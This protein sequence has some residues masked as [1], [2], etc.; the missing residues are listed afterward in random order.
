MPA[1][2]T[3]LPCIHYLR[4]TVNYNDVGI[5]GGVLVGTL[6]AG[7]QITD[8][9][10]NVETA[11]NG[12]SPVLTVGTNP[13][14][15]DNIAGAADINE[16]SATGQRVNAGLSL[17]FAADT[18][19]YVKYTVTGGTAGKAHVVIAYAGNYAGT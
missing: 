2:I 8:V 3:H 13:T 19:V 10:V 6:P 14:A 9:V 5:S 18:D 7:A 11:F 4:K 12:T 15:Y 1:T 16:T 17:E